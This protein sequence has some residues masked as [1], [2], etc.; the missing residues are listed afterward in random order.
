MD[1]L[2]SL[3]KKLK[4]DEYDLNSDDFDLAS[5]SQ[6]ENFITKAPST[7]YFQDAK[8]RLKENKIAMVSLAFII[9]VF[10]FA[11]IGP[12]FVKGDYTTQFRGDENLY[13]CLRYPFGTDKLGR[14]IMVRTMYG[15]R[16]S[17][18]VGIFASLIVLV[19]GTIYGSIAG[20]FG[21][22]VDAIR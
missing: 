15:T 19:I 10:I 7:S 18:I 12:F 17:L 20:Y 13:P 3:N 21:G 22:K 5:E 14:D 11:F 9:I 8:R 1:N 16:V 4:L 6:K 2:F